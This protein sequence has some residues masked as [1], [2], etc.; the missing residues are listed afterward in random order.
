MFCKGNPLQVCGG[1]SRLTMY[2]N[3]TAIVSSSSQSS[4]VISTTSS[5]ASSVSISSSSSITPEPPSQTTSSIVFSSSS[6]TTT[7]SQSVSSTSSSI[8]PEPPSQT[9]SSIVSSSASIS[10]SL[11]STSSSTPLSS[12]ST[13]L[14]S[15]TTTSPPSSIST[16]STLSTLTS[17]PTVSAIRGFASLG[18]YNDPATGPFQGHNMPKLFSND[19]M[20][21]DLCIS[22]ALARRSA[23]PAT[24]FLYAGVEYGRECYAATRAPTPQPASLVGPKA[25]TIPCKGDPS[26]SCGAGKMYNLYVATSVTVTGTVTN[27]WSSAG[28]V[29]T[30]S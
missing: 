8:T 1:S 18:C 27:Q 3:L 9:T 25:C 6:T 29:S 28:P 10:S 17:S 23:S 20:T 21:P 7:I 12:S 14:T 19:S 13:P 24:T 11:S 26:V 2:N 5:T 22:S 16:P 15:P 30:A 4:S